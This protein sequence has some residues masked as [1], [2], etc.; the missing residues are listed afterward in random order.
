MPNPFWDQPE[1]V[2]R[3]ALLGHV[4]GTVAAIDWESESLASR[5]VR[6]RHFAVLMLEHYHSRLI[7]LGR[8]LGIRE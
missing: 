6:G 5:N 8:T 2:E 1:T 3:F 7:D 4:M